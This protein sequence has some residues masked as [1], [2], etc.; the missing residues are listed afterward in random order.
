MRKTPAS[1]SARASG[2]GRCRSASIVSAA[3]RMVGS[4][5]WTAAR[6]SCSFDGNCV[7][8]KAIEL[9]RDARRRPRASARSIRFASKIARIGK[10]DVCFPRA[11]E[12]KRERRSTH[13]RNIA[14]L[15]Y[16][17]AALERTILRQSTGWNGDSI[18]AASEDCN[19]NQYGAGELRT[20]GIGLHADP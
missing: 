9:L 14:A 16:R 2:V 13:A 17:R 7:V 6:I 8:V 20:E 10:F 19:E 3:E 18:K 15:S 5:S 11:E 12:N 4:S 1:A